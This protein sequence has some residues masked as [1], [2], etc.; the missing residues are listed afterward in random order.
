MVPFELNYC[1]N[2][3]VI[4]NFYYDPEAAK[5]GNPYYYL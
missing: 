2:S 1:G 5:S 3:I 4:S